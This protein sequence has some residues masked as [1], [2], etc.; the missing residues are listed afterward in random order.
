MKLIFTESYQKLQ[1]KLASIAGEWDE[2]QSGK[3][4][5]RHDGGVMNWFEST[6]TIQFQGKPGKKERLEHLVA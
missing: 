3:K 4:V 2:S 6:G 5:L 1:E